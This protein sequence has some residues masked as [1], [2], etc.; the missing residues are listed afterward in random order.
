MVSEG[1][2]DCL[3][4][5]APLPRFDK[6]GDGLRG[7]GFCWVNYPDSR[8]RD[9]ILLYLLIPGHWTI[10]VVDSVKSR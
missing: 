7:F 6:S 8:C 10:K 3:P 2:S 1:K 4:R 5:L 9:R